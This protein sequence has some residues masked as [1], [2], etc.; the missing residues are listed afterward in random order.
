MKIKIR[1]S[2]SESFENGINEMVA[3]NKTDPIILEAIKNK[4]FATLPVSEYSENFKSEEMID[5]EFDFLSEIYIPPEQAELVN[6]RT[7]E[8][9][10][11]QGLPQ[12]F[13]KNT[14]GAS[15]GSKNRTLSDLDR[16]LQKE[17]AKI[18]SMK[19]SIGK[20]SSETTG[21]ILISLNLMK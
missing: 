19:K 18:N 5:I 11:E 15:D 13:I 16:D 10:Y 1:N 2:F 14:G 8:E 4:E 17:L 12:V 20:V 9:A 21:T 7:F 6:S 3:A